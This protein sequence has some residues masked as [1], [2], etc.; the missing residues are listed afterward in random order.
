MG[1][2]VILR[3]V[4]SHAISI[5]P[6]ASAASPAVSERLWLALGKVTNDDHHHPTLFGKSCNLSI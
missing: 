3:A 5:S 4:S 2:T 1:L 6:A